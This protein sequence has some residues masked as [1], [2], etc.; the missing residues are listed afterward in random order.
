MDPDTGWTAFAIVVKLRSIHIAS[1]GCRS[2]FCRRL[3]GCFSAGFP[4]AI[5]FQTCASAEA[6]SKAL[7]N[8]PNFS[9]TGGTNKQFL[10]SSCPNSTQKTAA[11]KALSG[12]ITASA[13]LI[14]LSQVKP[15]IGLPLLGCGSTFLRNLASAILLVLVS[16]TTGQEDR[17]WRNLRHH[18]DAPKGDG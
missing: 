7:H 12:F 9:V 4:G 8:I 18:L 1:S 3:Y 17:R 2:C 13:I 10:S 5:S 16:V 6:V 15:A 14:I 11:S